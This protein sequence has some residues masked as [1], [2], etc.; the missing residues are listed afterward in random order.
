MGPSSNTPTGSSHIAYTMAAIAGAGGAMGY[1]KG[2][3]QRS[4]AAGVLF[5]AGYVYAGYLINS[6]PERGFRFATTVSA[7]MAGVMGYRW[8][9]TGKVMP[10]GVLAGLGGASAA[11]HYAKLVEWTE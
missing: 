6:A 9:T 5:G 1:V 8:Y 11:Y 3:S 2:R 10:A 4:L 7:L